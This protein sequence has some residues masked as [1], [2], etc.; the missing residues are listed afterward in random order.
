[1]SERKTFWQAKGEIVVVIATLMVI[2]AG[3]TFIY[4]QA[5]SGNDRVV[6]T[7]RWYNDTIEKVEEYF[8]DE[9]QILRSRTIYGDDGKTV[10]ES[11]EYEFS[12]YDANN[13][14]KT[15]LVSS[16]ER[17]QDGSVE[18]KTFN[19]L[20][21]EL[22]GREVFAADGKTIQVREYYDKGVLARR[23]TYDT[24]GEVELKIETFDE[25]GNFIQVFE[26][27][28][29]LQAEKRIYQKGNNKLK[30]VFLSELSILGNEVKVVAEYCIAFWD[31]GKTAHV[32]LNKPDMSLPPEIEIF[33]P[34]GYL[35]QSA[36]LAEDGKSLTVTEYDEDNS[37]QVKNITYW[38][39]MVGSYFTLVKLEKYE[40]GKLTSIVVF[41]EFS[42]KAKQ[43]K[44]LDLASGKVISVY[45][46][47]G[48]GQIEKEEKLDDN[49]KVIETKIIPYTERKQLELELPKAINIAE[50]VKEF[51]EQ[52]R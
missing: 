47:D 18:K 26:I 39:V 4:I 6:V 17:M 28:P 41:D 11:K 50:I 27:L 14:G 48:S 10:L 42:R 15:V 37:N 1:M 9:K 2:I 29:S 35:L 44:N 33:S 32:R 46:L 16:L 3:V 49:G 38:D 34:I 31:D 8:D 22:K 43:I 20:G 19:E 52:A 5:D 25:E 40:N 12:G 21:Q 13:G 7:K 36:K 23:Q 30:Y 24:N 45:Y 51:S